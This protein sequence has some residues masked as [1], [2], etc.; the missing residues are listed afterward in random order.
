MCTQ[1]IQGWVSIDT[2]TWPLI[3]TQSTSWS[4]LDWPLHRYLVNTRSTSDNSRL[5]FTDT[6]LSVNQC[7]WLTV[8]WVSLTRLVLIKTSMRCWSRF[9]QVSIEM[10]I[11]CQLRVNQG[12]GL[13]LTCRCLQYTW[14]EES[15][16]KKKLDVTEIRT[17]VFTST[18][19]I[20]TLTSEC[21]STMSLSC[22]KSSS[23]YW[24]IITK[25]FITNTVKIISLAI[26]VHEAK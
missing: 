7:K 17:P 21:F 12:Y 8:N 23:R 9:E 10:S 20:L 13:R 1:G 15:L 22:V 2:L 6:P 4:T 18:T 5:I 26:G 25:K 14:S 3:D 11:E 19:H 16:C 24:I